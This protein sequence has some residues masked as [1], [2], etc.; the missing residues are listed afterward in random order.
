MARLPIPGADD[1]QWGG[2]LNDYLLTS[3]NADGSI[4]STAA[5]TSVNSQTGAVTLTAADVSAIPTSQKGAASGVATLDGSTKVPAAQ[6]PDLD[7][8]KITTGVFDANR[9]PST[10]RIYTFSKTNTT[11]AVEA[12]LHRFYNDTGKTWT[13][14]YIRATVGVAPTGA[15]LIVDVNRDGTTVF[16]TQANRPTIA[17]SAN[18]SG[19]VTNMNVTTVAD[20]SYLT[21]D[22]DQVGSTIAGGALTVQVGVSY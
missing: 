7:A 11:L 5:A 13:I 21:V 20:G 22:I 4:K 18:S 9:I 6:I 1:N 14:Q 16:T 12:G 15:S 19:K 17:A 8:A 10:S 3:H 2:I